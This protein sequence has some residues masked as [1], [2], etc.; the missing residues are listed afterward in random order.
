MNRAAM[1]GLSL[2]EML[3]VLVLASLL[4]TL[5]MQG[6]G[7]FLAAVERAQRHAGHDALAALPQ[8]WF[9]ESVRSMMPFLDPVRGFVGDAQGFEGISLTA[10]ASEAGYPKRIRWSIEGGAVRYREADGV[11]WTLTEAGNNAG[12]FEYAD[13]DGIWGRQWRH[14]PATLQ[15]MPS[16]V[17]LLAVDGSVLWVAHMALHPTPVVNPRAQT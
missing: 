15:W 9:S 7:F 6:L 1:R 3:V 12:F 16:Q 8:Q 11:D 10:L 4:S 13:R 5:L 14:T 2:L 17:R